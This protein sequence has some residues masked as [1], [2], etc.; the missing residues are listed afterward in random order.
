[1]SSHATRRVRIKI[2][3]KAIGLDQYRFNE[4][5]HAGDYP[6]AP[7]TVAGKVRTFGEDDLVGLYY[8]KHL[9]D[10]GL[11]RARA[12]EL[13]CSLLQ[14]VQDD[15]KGKDRV[16]HVVGNVAARFMTDRDAIA[17]MTRRRAVPSVGNVVAVQF[18]EVGVVRKLVN[19]AVDEELPESARP[20]RRRTTDG[21]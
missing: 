12:G 8:F 14:F 21:R 13:A 16:A 7:A 15:G 11:P 2:A 1:M 5:V 17:T 18:F 3:M 9:Q 4:A 20:H 6:C 19:A 10:K